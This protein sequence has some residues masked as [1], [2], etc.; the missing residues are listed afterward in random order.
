MDNITDAKLSACVVDNL[1]QIGRFKSMT[2]DAYNI[3]KDDYYGRYTIVGLPMMDESMLPEEL[4]GIFVSSSTS[5]VSISKI[6][7]G[8]IIPI[9]LLPETT[10][11]EMISNISDNT[12]IV[13][14]LTSNTKAWIYLFENEGL[15]IKYNDDEIIIGSSAANLT[16]GGQEVIADGKFTLLGPQC[17]A[18]LQKDDVGGDIAPMT[19]LIPYGYPMPYMPNLNTKLVNNI[20]NLIKFVGGA[21]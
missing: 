11:N 7:I 19:E 2:G 15:N 1:K 13:E 17:K 8:F 6:S 5:V 12:S 10:I 14:R 3:D 16:F 18:V 20:L 9:F 4:W 21:L